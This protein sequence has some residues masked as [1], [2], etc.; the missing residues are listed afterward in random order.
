MLLE[1]RVMVSDFVSEVAEEMLFRPSL[2]CGR[3]E[4]R[5]S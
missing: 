3:V 5:G 1:M 4:G 2:F